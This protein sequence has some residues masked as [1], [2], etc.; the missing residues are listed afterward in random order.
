MIIKLYFNS[1]KKIN[2]DIYIYICESTA[3]ESND[4]I[5]QHTIWEWL[6]FLKARRGKIGDVIRMRRNVK[7]VISLKINHSSSYI[8]ISK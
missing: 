3:C 6:F 8:H 2:K 4:M 5:C 7:K 1:G